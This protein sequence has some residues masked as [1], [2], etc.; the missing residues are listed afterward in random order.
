MR[1]H[2]DIL[3]FRLNGKL[4]CCGGGIGFISPI[5]SKRSWAALPRDTNV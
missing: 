2:M 5:D 1:K 3:K 4:C